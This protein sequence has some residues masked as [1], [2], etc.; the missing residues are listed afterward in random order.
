MVSA[1][2]ADE[3]A[4]AVGQSTDDVM[5]ALDDVPDEKARSLFLDQPGGVDEPLSANQR[6]FRDIG[7]TGADRLFATPENVLVKTG[8]EAGQTARTGTKAIAAGAVGTAG[9]LTVPPLLG[10]LDRSEMSAQS[11]EQVRQVLED[12]NLSPEQK[13]EI[14]QDLTES[15]VLA[16]AQNDD[17]G[18]SLLGGLLPDNLFS[19]Q[20]FLLVILAYAGVKA[21]GAYGSGGGSTGGG[22]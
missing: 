5:Q 19:T 4:Q 2:L 11:R 20:T 16:G 7:Q 14:I 12:P 6:I 1:S 17:G 13:R 10:Q 3:I 9:L 15:G 18:D 22:A 8:E 21:V